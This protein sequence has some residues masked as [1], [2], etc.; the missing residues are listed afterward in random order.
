MFLNKIELGNINKISTLLRLNKVIIYK[1]TSNN[2]A[3]ISPVCSLSIHFVFL[4]LPL[5]ITAISPGVL[6]FSEPVP[7]HK[8]PLIKVTVGE[9]VLTP[10]MFLSISPFP[11]ILIPSLHPECSPSLLFVPHPRPPIVVPIIVAVFSLPLPQTVFPSSL[12]LVLI[13]IPH[14][15]L[16]VFVVI[17][18]LPRINALR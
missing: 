7:I 6:P 17:R 9:S 18:P 11:I 4:P 1:Q 16:S 5:V 2:Y 12:V 15:S 13:R 8:L 3:I 10:P 14:Y